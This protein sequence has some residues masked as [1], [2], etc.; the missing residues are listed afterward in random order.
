MFKSVVQLKNGKFL[1]APLVAGRRMKATA[2]ESRAYN[3]GSRSAGAVARG[4][5]GAQVK[6]IML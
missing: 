3:F 4:I 6:T 2:L 5:A 1:S